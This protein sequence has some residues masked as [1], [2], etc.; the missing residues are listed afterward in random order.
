M[1]QQLTMM[2]HQAARHFAA[3]GRAGLI[4]GVSV[5]VS[6]SVTV[7]TSTLYEPMLCLVLQGAKQVM[8]GDRVLRYDPASYFVTSLDLPVSGRIAEASPAE[9][10]ICVSLTLNRDTIASLLSDTAVRPEG[11]TAGFGVSPVTPQLVDA[12]CR[13]LSLFD[14]PEDVPALA[15]MLER[16]IL[17]RVMQGPQGGVLRQIARDDSQLSQVRQAIRWIKAHFNETIRIETLAEIARMS[18]AS[19]H[20]HFRTATAMSPLQYQKMLRLQEARR[21]MILNGNTARTAYTVGYESAS[22]FSR[23]Y[24]RMFGTPPSRDAMRLRGQ[25]PGAE[26]ISGVA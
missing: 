22:Q 9:P 12:W 25:D 5:F 21:L 1:Q 23:E 20:R 18:P 11:Q 15:P 13:M 24:A 17:Y 7:P 4:P 19:F 16:E 10:Y 2:R 8:V 14:A 26:D 3:S 6:P